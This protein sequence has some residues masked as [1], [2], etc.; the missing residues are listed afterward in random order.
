M[1]L[2]GTLYQN[3]E[4]LR[5]LRSAQ[6]RIR[7]SENWCRGELHQVVDGIEQWCA[8]GAVL[9][10]VNRWNSPADELLC[11]AALDMGYV[12]LPGHELVSLNNCSDHP[13]VMD[14]FD[15]AREKRISEILE[16]ET[17]HV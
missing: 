5:V 17:V 11:Q 7:N 3:D 4:T 14:M 6:E 15:L 16:K 12:D 13:T 2:D 9:T 10:E 1:P 8:R